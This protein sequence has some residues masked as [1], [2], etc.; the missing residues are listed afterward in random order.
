MTLEFVA[1]LHAGEGRDLYRMIW[2]SLHGEGSWNDNPEVVVLT[3]T[4]HK[5]NIDALSARRAA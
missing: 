5:L 2:C 3:F 1:E 4:V